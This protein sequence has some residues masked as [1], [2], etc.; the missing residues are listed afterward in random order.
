MVSI[1]LLNNKHPLQNIL[2]M[3]KS[4]EKV[5]RDTYRDKETE[6]GGAS[7]SVCSKKESVKGKA[8]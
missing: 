4:T 5:N 8:R 7:Q 1:V 6:G 3:K 2:L